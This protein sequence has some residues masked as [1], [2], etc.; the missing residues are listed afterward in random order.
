MDEEKILVILKGEDKTK[1]IEHFSQCD[2]D[3]KIN[4]K[5]YKNKQEYPYSKIN[6]IVKEKPIVVELKEKDIYYKN[7]ILFNIEKVIRFEEF[8]KIIYR[9]GETEV[10]RYKDLS[11]KSNSIENLNKNII[12]YFKEISNY[13]KSGKEEEESEHEEN[14]ESF[15]KREYEKLN[16]INQESILNYYIN[17]IDL[18]KPTEV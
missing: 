13:V 16:Y 2:N 10:F 12:G 5:F 15:L 3:G 9:S 7:Q 4:I 11:F 1:D 18:T 14:Q 8:V 17:K 6:V